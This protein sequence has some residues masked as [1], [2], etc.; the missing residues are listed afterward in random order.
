MQ[1]KGI[2]S[3]KFAKIHN[4]LGSDKKFNSDKMMKSLT[5]HLDGFSKRCIFA[6]TIEEGNKYVFQIA[7]RCA[8]IIDDTDAKPD[9]E[10]FLSEE[11][12]FHIANG[13]VSPILALGRERMRIS[14]NTDIAIDVYDRL[15]ADNGIIDPCKRN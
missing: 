8:S 11:T 5:K 9:F 13:K 4:L 7:D 14:G 2:L 10:I 3:D 6:I 15:A 12:A 1:K